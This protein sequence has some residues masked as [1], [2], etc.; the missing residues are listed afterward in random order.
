M[1]SDFSLNTDE[2]KIIRGNCSFLERKQQPKYRYV[3]KI[4]EIVSSTQ[5]IRK[6]SPATTLLS[7]AIFVAAEQ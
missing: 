3:V 4:D 2:L 6:V 7:A 1:R 5:I